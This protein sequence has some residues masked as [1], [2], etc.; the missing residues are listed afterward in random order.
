M[1]ER[2]DKTKRAAE[3]MMQKQKPTT[4][5]QVLIKDTKTIKRPLV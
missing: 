1:L 5:E 3:Q 4:V 2:Q